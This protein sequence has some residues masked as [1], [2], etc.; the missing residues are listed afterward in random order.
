M[1]TLAPR[2]R[3]DWDTVMSDYRKLSVSFQTMIRNEAVK[4]L[5]EFGFEEIGSSDINHSIYGLAC[6]A[7]S[8]DD[9][10]QECLDNFLFEAYKDR[11]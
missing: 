8:V 3:P 2:T 9:L 10:L 5:E 4:S 6:G 7:G 11:E 1:S